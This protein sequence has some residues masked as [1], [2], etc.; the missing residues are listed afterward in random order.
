MWDKQQRE[1]KGVRTE[2]KETQTQFV[3]LGKLALE[4]SFQLKF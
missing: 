4:S 2:G 1:R 3:G